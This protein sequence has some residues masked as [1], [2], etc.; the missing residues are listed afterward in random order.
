[1]Y[2]A[3]SSSQLR[4]HGVWFYASDPAGFDAASIRQW[5]GDFSNISNVATR[6]AR[7]GQCFS[8]TQ[9]TVEV[10][11]AE[12]VHEGDIC[13]PESVHPISQQPYCF[14]DGC[15]KISPELLQEVWT[16]LPHIT[17]QQPAA[18]QIRYRYEFS[19]IIL[20]TIIRLIISVVAE[21]QRL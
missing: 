9:E 11:L 13:H 8:S 20:M 5:M 4:D 17:A 10:S 18:L 19:I 3:A 21:I 15:G 14:S 1:M 16:S 12:E 6:V 7:M 2:V